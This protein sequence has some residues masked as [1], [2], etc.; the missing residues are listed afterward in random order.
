MSRLIVFK[1]GRSGILP[2][3]GDTFANLGGDVVEQFGVLVYIAFNDF[4]EVVRS[5]VLHGIEVRVAVHL[6]Q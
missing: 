1:V 2:F 3:D 4:V 6:F 5:F